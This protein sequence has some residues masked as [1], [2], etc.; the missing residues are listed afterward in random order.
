MITLISKGFKYGKPDTN[1]LFDVSYFKNPWR[2]PDEDPE[3]FMKSQE[4]FYSITNAIYGVIQAY[5]SAFPDEDLRFGIC[6]SAGEYRSP[7]IARFLKKK[8]EE[9]G[10]S[11]KLE[12]Q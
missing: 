9:I 6:C 2:S 12:H 5:N 3:E 7:I 10:L 8:L 4:S 1:F 11:V